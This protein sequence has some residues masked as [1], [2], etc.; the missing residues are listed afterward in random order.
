MSYHGSIGRFEEIFTSRRPMQKL[1]NVRRKNG[2]TLQ[3]WHLGCSSGCCIV[4]RVIKSRQ[5][6]F[7][8]RILV[9]L[10]PMKKIQVKQLINNA[11][12]LF[13]TFWNILKNSN[14]AAV[15]FSESPTRFPTAAGEK[16]ILSIDCRDSNEG[17]E[18]LSW[19]LLNNHHVHTRVP[20]LP[21]Q[22]INNLYLSWSHIPISSNTGRSLLV[23]NHPKL[24]RLYV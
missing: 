4:G 2:V 17:G 15:G 18:S 23:K 9:F 22:V 3:P 10:Y 11:Q 16:N 24:T 1:W 6:F 20:P 7:T 21:H 12:L 19:P 14:S 5:Q 13:F 8:V